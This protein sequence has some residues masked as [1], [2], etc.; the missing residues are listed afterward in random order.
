M[1]CA[2]R[3]PTPV[4]AWLLRDGCDTGEKLEGSSLTILSITTCLTFVQDLLRY[5]FG[6]VYCGDDRSPAT[7]I[8][9][10]VLELPLGASLLGPMEAEK[11]ACGY[12]LLGCK[13]YIIHTRSG[14]GL[15]TQARTGSSRVEGL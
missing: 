6:L 3:D 7:A 1:F 13:A 9:H 14:R 2:A 10:C 4:G 5:Q 8:E 12:T 15:D 11:S